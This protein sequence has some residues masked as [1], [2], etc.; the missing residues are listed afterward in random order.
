MTFYDL[1][2]LESNALD[3]GDRGGP[4]KT[5]IFVY[6]FLFLCILHKPP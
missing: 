5:H 2:T 4:I 1:M 6:V 3:R